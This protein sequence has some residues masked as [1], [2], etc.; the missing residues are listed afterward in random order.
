MRVDALD[1]ALPEGLIATSPAEPRDRARLMV[2][3]R[4]TGKI[5]HHAVAD[6]PGLGI[7]RAGDLMVFNRSR[8]LPAYYTAKRAKTGGKLKGLY[9]GEDKS[10]RW[11][12]MLESRGKLLAGERIR[13]DERSELTLI[14]NQ[15][16]GAWVAEYAGPDDALTLLSRIGAAPLPP[17]I[18][19][20]RKA[21]HLPEVNAADMARYNTVYARE[22]GSV[23]APTAGLHFTPELLTAL[24]RSGVKR[25][26]VTLHVGLGT[27][28]PIRCED[29]RDHPIHSEAIAISPEAVSALIAVRAADGRITP[30]GTTSVRAI[31]SLP[32]GLD[33]VADRG[34]R[35]DTDLFIT[36]DNGFA[37][38]FTDHLLTNFHL[39]RSTL[40]ALVAALPGV[41][42]D[43]LLGW[44]RVAIDAGYRFYSYGDAMLIV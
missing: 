3:D 18:R 32:A 7:F 34:Y 37:F 24:E 20:A 8:V 6:L 1:Y 35:T 28:A 25:A 17:Y 4:E 42:I 2:V 39:P 23:A 43:R 27:F 33:T 41:G 21:L 29:V 36:P 26:E 31:E 14:E 16:S 15:G 13:L 44:Y 12:T 30:V 10:G 22:S 5:G 40:L 19:K 38:R 11:R 9:L